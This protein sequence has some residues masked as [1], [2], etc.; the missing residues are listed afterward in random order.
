MVSVSRRTLLTTAAGA[1]VAAT[2]TITPAASAAGELRTFRRT[3]D[4]AVT[5]LRAVAPG[6]TAFPE[7]TRFEKWTYSQNG[8]WI[9]GFWPG[10]L[11]LASIYSGDARF[12]TL[13]MA[14]AEKLAPRQYE[15]RDHDLGF[16]FYPSWVTGWRLTGDEKWRT[17]ALNAAASLIQRYNEK[18]RFI[19]AWGALGTPGNA[20]RVIV[21]TMMNLDLLTFASKQTGDRKYLDI[22]VSHAKT[23]ERVF[24][25]PDGS[26]PHVFDFDP[27]TG[28]EIGPDT[29]QGYSPTSCWSRGQAWGIY[30]FTTMYRR[31]GDPLFLRTAQ[32]MADFALR[33]LTPDNVPVWDY[34]AP[35]APYD[36]KDSSAGAV[37]ACGLLDLAKVANRPQYR[38]AAIRILTALC[39]TCLTAKST[40]AEAIM[41][42][43]TRNRR[44][45][46][47][48]EVSL[49]YGD[50][51]LLE[52]ILRVLMP[53][54]IDRAIDLSSV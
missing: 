16:L 46:D 26:T 12:R 42:R 39:D 53:R 33:A 1:A 51:Y 7:I 19:R 24:V 8:G 23:T 48:V 17:G 50:Y 43:G 25:R 40:R 45:E 4:Y 2:T 36:I 52:G 37:M 28:A 22:A 14:S 47:G 18:G 21:D 27:D 6:V 9:G 35:Q 3:A 10:T 20:G 41:A 38:E 11:W 54:E 49:P 34:L 44:A 32:R 31:S 15:T 30:G 5:K 13:A 29:V